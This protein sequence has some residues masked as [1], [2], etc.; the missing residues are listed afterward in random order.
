M[1]TDA[2]LRSDLIGHAGRDISHPL[3]LA[4]KSLTNWPVD[5]FALDLREPDDQWVAWLQGGAVGF[6]SGKGPFND[7]SVSGVVR[8]LRTVQSVVVTTRYVDDGARSQIHRAITVTFE[9]G[10]DLQIDPGSFVADHFRDHADGFVAG[11]LRAIAG[12]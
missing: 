8:P 12:V 3:L 5:E 10:A 11:L 4:V 6:V 7:P 1:T 9:A 2:E